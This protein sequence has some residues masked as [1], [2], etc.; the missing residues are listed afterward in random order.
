[1]S[2]S[3]ERKQAI[4]SKL[5][6]PQSLSISALSKQE[7][8]PKG[9]LYD[10]RNQA[11]LSG[12]LVPSGTKVKADNWSSADKFLAVIETA[13][14]NQSELSVWCRERGI[15]PEQIE[16]WRLA[17]EQANEWQI[18][19][20]KQIAEQQ[21]KDKNK[22]ALLEQDLR[23]KEK[24][25]AETAALLVLRKKAAAIWGRSDYFKSVKSGL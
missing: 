15:Y 11:R 16:A 12:K 22:I 4:L 1:M 23:K 3:K 2:Y 6:P 5:L 20:K 13:S 19:K 9:T 14:K 25:L 24:A 8:I 21:K 10:W 7:G 18:S 17:C